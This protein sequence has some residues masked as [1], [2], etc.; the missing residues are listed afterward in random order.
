MIWF[1]KFYKASYGGDNRAHVSIFPFLV[2]I[3]CGSQ[4]W[5]VTRVEHRLVVKVAFFWVVTPYSVVEVYRRSEGSC[6]VRHQGDLDGGCSKHLCDVSNLLP[7]CI[8]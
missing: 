3:S 6:C 4:T 5:S 2:V 8:M 7:H 1:V